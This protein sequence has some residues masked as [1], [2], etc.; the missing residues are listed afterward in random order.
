MQKC[1]Y[2]GLKINDYHQISRLTVRDREPETMCLGQQI[3]IW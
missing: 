2:L 3:I 1:G